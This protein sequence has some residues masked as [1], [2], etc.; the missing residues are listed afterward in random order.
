MIKVFSMFPKHFSCSLT[1]KKR[2]GSFH[3]QLST[4]SEDV[5]ADRSFLVII[6]RIF[7]PIDIHERVSSENVDFAIVKTNGCD[8]DRIN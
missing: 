7:H 2:I 3:S 6:R 4:K 5:W 1:L 8:Q